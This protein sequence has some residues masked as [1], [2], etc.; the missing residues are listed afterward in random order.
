MSSMSTH[1]KRTILRYR[2]GIL[3]NQ[4]HAVRF[5]RSTDPMCPLPGCHHSDSA[6]HML[7]GCQNHII[8][9]LNTE[10]HNIAG[11]MVI[12]ALSKSPV[13]AGLV[14]TDVGS[15]FKLAHHNLQLPTHASNRTVTDFFF[16]CN[17]QERGRLNSS[18]PDA[19]LITPCNAKPTSHIVPSIHSQHALRRPIRRT[20]RA[21]RVKHPHELHV[22]E[23]HMH[24]IEIKFCEDTRPEH[25]LSAA[26]QQHANRCNLISTKAKTIYPIL[27]GVGG[28]I[29]T[30]HSLKHL[31]KL[32]LDHQRATKLA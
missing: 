24:I 3:Y 21:I 19:I 11:I 1:M 25:Q 6:L 17:I 7:S 31:K 13:G 23:R 18:R 32:R 29:Y 14:Y 9:K 5:K 20:T 26:K 16:P 30:E 4:K 10:R 2:T 12:K 15:D 22:N 28:T 8:S 27:L